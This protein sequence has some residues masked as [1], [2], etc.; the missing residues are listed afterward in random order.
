VTAGET[1]DDGNLTSG[2]GC[3]A[4][5][6]T[7]ACGNGVPTAGEACDDGNLASGD[8]CSPAC[9]VE[10]A[11][12]CGLVPQ[13]GCSGGTPACDVDDNGDTSCR[14]VTSQG[15]SNNHCT[16]DTACKAG[17][18][19]LGD[20]VASHTAW[21]ARFC[22]ADSD[23]LGTGSRCVIDLANSGGTTI[24]VTVCSNACDPYAQTG[25]PTGMGCV[26]RTATVADYTDCR[27]M[28]TKLDGQSC[29]SH[30]ECLPGSSCVGSAG[31]TICKSYCIVGNAG[32]CAAGQT[33]TPF[34]GNMTIGTVEYGACN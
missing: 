3:D 26:G 25:C 29:T 20:G 6:T 33:C 30:S 21:C 22:L 16:T 24:G 14:A 28:G 27:Y 18:T 34:V 11:T 4:N 17:Y 8:G 13:A 7:T 10:N 5:C 12:A 15:T 19:C 31:N 1:C 32:S 23:C 9:Q 2:D